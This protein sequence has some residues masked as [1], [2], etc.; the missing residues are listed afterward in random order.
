MAGRISFECFQYLD[1][2]VKAIGSRPLPA[3]PM[4]MVMEKAMLPGVESVSE[5]IRN[6]LQG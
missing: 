4:N 2:P 5:A 6:L 1:A 3:V